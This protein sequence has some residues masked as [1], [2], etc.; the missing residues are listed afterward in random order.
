VLLTWENAYSLFV[1]V[2]RRFS[3]FHGLRR[4]GDGPE[5][6]CRVPISTTR[7]SQVLD[8]GEPERPPGRVRQ[9]FDPG[10][11]A[12]TV[13]WSSCGWAVSSGTGSPDATRSSM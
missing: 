7:D 5:G 1:I 12:A 13:T 9:R 2:A 10:P 11:Y 6:V 4:P 3:S 8:L